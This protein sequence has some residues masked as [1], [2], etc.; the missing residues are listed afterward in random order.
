MTIDSARPAA[1]RLMRED[2]GMS[3]QKVGRP[4]IVCIEERGDEYLVIGVQK[5]AD[6]NSLT[7]AERD[8]VRLALQ[9]L[10]DREIAACRGTSARTVANQLRRVFERLGVHSR[11]ELAAKLAEPE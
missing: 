10:S 4:S 9:G 6:S 5:S 11:A 7:T 1:L 8:V 2:D 3:S